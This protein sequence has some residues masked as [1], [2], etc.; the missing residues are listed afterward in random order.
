MSNSTAQPVLLA[1]NASTH[2]RSA[3][4]GV[5]WRVLSAAGLLMVIA[6]GLRIWNMD[7]TFETSDQAAMPYMICTE[8]GVTWVFAH[9]Y[10]PVLPVIHKAWS[11]AWCGLGFS[12]DETAARMP[13]ALLGMALVGVSYVLARRLHA[14]R[15]EA[16][17]TALF[18]A[19]VP[20]LVVDSHYPWGD[21]GVWVLFGA[22]ALWSMLAYVDTRR[23]IYLWVTAFAL[24]T[25]CLSS[26]YAFALPLTLMAGWWFKWRT[27]AAGDSADGGTVTAGRVLAGFVLPC[28]L[29]LV[30]IVTSWRW[31]GGGQIGHLL[32]KKD[33]ET[34]GLHFHQIPRLPGMWAG[35]FGLIF[36]MIAA[37]AMVWV[38]V[39]VGRWRR[40]GLV[41]IWAWMGLLP[42]VLIADWNAT[43]YAQY[44]MFEVV[45]AASIAGVLLLCRMW[46]S[47]RGGRIVSGVVGVLAFLQLGMASVDVMLPDVS[48]GRYTG[49]RT[50]WGNV[51]PDSGAKAAGWYIRRH[52][53]AEALVMA[54]H[55]NEGMEVPVAEYYLGRK[56]LAHYDLLP[57][58]VGPLWEAMRDDVDVVIVE[59][60][61]ED[62]VRGR[63]GWDCVFTALRDGEVVRRIYA[64]RG[65]AAKDFRL[66]VGESNALYDRDCHA[67]RVPYPMAAA[68]GFADALGKYQR[69]IRDLKAMRF[70]STLPGSDVP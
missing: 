17:I 14:G 35:Q 51:R 42:F 16:W 57:Q 23:T 28:V 36:G 63:A 20:C 52:V 40:I 48:L 49:V 18:V 19:V 44:Y 59:P 58:A 41:G 6:A 9:H 64:R 67:A 13:V 56:I 37:A 12:Y 60:G 39:A 34:F 55:T 66:E 54:L 22:I 29:A 26:L 45:Y 7:A 38:M 46:R 21:H 68:P 31:T 2:T 50:G 69:C 24:F 47:G 33:V 1:G 5:S 15:P 11:M 8:Y 62:L 53:P 27:R 30:V 10:G 4:A 32:D 3:V 43:G 70:E 65:V 25:H 61:H